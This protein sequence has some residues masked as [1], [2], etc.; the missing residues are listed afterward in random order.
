M[1]RRVGFD[2]RFK[3]AYEEGWELKGLGYDYSKTLM[4]RTL[5]NYMFRNQNLKEFLENHLTPIMVKYINSVK[6]LRIYNNF[7][8]PKD[9]DKIN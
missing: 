9:Y 6:F 5:S 2:S 1:D 7:A 4:N 3:A 8:V